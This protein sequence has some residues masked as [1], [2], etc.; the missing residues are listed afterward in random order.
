VKNEFRTRMITK[1]TIDAFQQLLSNETWDNIYNEH[2]I[3]DNFN[4]FLKTSINIFEASFLVAHLHK[5]KDN[6]WIKKGIII[7][8]KCKR[9]LYILNKNYNDPKLK[10]Y[11]KHYCTILRKVIRMTKKIYFSH[12]I[13]TS[14]NK[15]KTTWNIIN[16][17]IDRPQNSYPMNPFFKVGHEETPCNEVVEA[18]NDYFLNV[19]EI[20]KTQTYKKCTHFIISETSRKG[21]FPHALYTDNGRR[22]E[23]YNK[24]P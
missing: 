23:I 9:S 8:S 10:L 17:V 11:Y 21:F 7:P 3:N 1:G 14:K 13:E 18:L 6:S 4:A 2:D 19:T 16:N 5:N 20:L 15:T 22:S 12:L 24:V